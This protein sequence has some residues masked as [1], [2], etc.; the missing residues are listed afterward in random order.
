MTRA[1]ASRC[2]CLSY[3]SYLTHALHFSLYSKVLKGLVKE[4]DTGAAHVDFKYGD[5]M[6]VMSKTR[7]MLVMS[8]SRWSSHLSTRNA[9]IWLIQSCVLG[10]AAAEGVYD[11]PPS[12]NLGLCNLAAELLPLYTERMYSSTYTHVLVYVL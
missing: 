8:G 9:H 10:S 12:T 5:L 1:I 6:T 11:V 4:L 3:L 2:S 7:E